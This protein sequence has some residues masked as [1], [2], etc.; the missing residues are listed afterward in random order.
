MNNK[1][2]VILSGLLAFSVNMTVSASL[3]TVNGSGGFTGIS[4]DTS[5]ELSGTTSTVNGST[6][7]S[8][9]SWGDSSSLSVAHEANVGIDLL[10][11]NYLLSSYSFENNF[12]EEGLELILMST[13]ESLLK[14]TSSSSGAILSD[15]GSSFSISNTETSDDED[16]AGGET[17]DGSAD[18][19]E[20][21]HAIWNDEG[22]GCDDYLDVSSSG[23][24]NIPL[25]IDGEH[26]KFST[27]FSYDTSG[28]SPIAGSRLW[29][30]EEETTDFYTIGRL[31]SVA[32]AVPESSIISLFGL[33]LL[34]FAFSQKRLARKSINNKSNK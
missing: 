31:T 25:L 7:N 18:G 23:V 16:C 2:K 21:E 26:Y 34:G 29:G 14:F 12:M 9:V 6:V 30:L 13:L 15:F 8:S 17:E 22:V 3:I 27:F 10:D 11:T 20:H 5:A 19:E 33:G 1:T 4:G 24:F 28:T 32:T